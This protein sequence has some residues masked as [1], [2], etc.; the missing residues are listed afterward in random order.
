MQSPTR[1][2]TSGQ[3]IIAAQPSG[4]ASPPTPI[5]KLARNGLRLVSATI[6]HTQIQASSISL[7][8]A[9]L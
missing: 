1:S 5:S 6:D 7:I 3:Q 4:R 9:K 8:T 2:S